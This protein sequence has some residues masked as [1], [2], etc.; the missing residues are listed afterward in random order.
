MVLTS[1][2]QILVMLVWTLLQW[3]EFILLQV[4][5]LVS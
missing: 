2:L 3:N 5:N 4:L 1:G